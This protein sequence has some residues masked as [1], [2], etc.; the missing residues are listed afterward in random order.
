MFC[1]SLGTYPMNSWRLRMR[2]K[3]KNKGKMRDII[4]QYLIGV[5]IS[6]TAGLLLHFI[7]RHW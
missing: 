3:R 7:Q 5:V 4:E 6:L 1:P 2:R